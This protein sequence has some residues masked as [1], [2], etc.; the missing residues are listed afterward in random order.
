MINHNT[1]SSA[2]MPYAPPMDEGI[3]DP[4][5]SAEGEL[6]MMR[7]ALDDGEIEHAARHLA[8]A[9]GYQPDLPEAHEALAGLVA[10]LG[11]GALDLF[12]VDGDVYIGTVA[13]RAHVLA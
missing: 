6:A 10:K 4:R 7:L 2:A 5:L 11:A 8:G 9:M 3:D 12:P 13:A 1:T